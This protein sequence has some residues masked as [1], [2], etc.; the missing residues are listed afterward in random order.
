VRQPPLQTVL[1][2]AR[3]RQ[4]N[5]YAKHEFA[6]VDGVSATLTGKVL[7]SIRGDF[8][9]VRRVFNGTVDDDVEQIRNAL[10]M[11]GSDVTIADMIGDRDLNIRRE[12]YS[13]PWLTDLVWA[14]AGRLGHSAH[15]LPDAIVVEDDHV[16]GAMPYVRLPG[17]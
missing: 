17:D 11:T 14:S 3:R 7:W 8:R 6:S 1:D 15:F 16:C 9:M 4:E 2:T 12:S 13:T 5:G 10:G